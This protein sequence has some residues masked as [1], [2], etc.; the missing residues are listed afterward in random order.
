MEQPTRFGSRDCL[1]KGPFTAG[2]D[3]SNTNY[4]ARTVRV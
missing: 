2:P 1:F 4:L 3:Y